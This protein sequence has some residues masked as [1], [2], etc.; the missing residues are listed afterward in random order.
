MFRLINKEILKKKDK[1]IN[2]LTVLDF[3]GFVEFLLQLAVY[4][5]SYE[6]E[7]LPVEY[8]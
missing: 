1:G 3:E 7:L 6:S 5:Y 8:L 4:I 2:S